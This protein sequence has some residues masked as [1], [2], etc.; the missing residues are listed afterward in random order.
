VDLEFIQERG[1]FFDNSIQF[2]GDIHNIQLRIVLALFRLF[3]HA[4]DFDLVDDANEQ[5]AEEIDKWE[6]AEDT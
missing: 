3:F 4:F 5:L 2:L 6:V 1:Y